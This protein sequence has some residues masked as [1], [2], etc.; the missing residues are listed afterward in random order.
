ML[1][2]PEI[3]DEA[4]QVSRLEKLLPEWQ[5]VPLYHTFLA[6]RPAGTD[7]LAALKDFP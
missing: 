4:T 2:T 1:A 5:K 3:I 6:Q 7:V